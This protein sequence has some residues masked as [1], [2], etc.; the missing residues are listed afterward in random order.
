MLSCET[1]RT[2]AQRDCSAAYCCCELIQLVLRSPLDSRPYL[3]SWSCCLPPPGQSVGL[4]HDFAVHW[5]MQR[6]RSRSKTASEARSGIGGAP[7]TSHS[8][9]VIWRTE[10]RVARRHLLTVC[11]CCCCCCFSPLVAVAQWAGSV[12]PQPLASRPAARTSRSIDD[13]A[14]ASSLDCLSGT[15]V[16]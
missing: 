6:S 4:S 7:M 3:R 14:S 10:I 5:K 1:S 8:A 15:G 16:A 2:P 13:A 9:I 12:R 11:C